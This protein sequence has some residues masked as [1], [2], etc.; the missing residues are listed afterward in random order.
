MASVKSIL[1]TKGTNVVILD[2]TT[3]VLKAVELMAEVNIGCVIVGNDEEALGVFTER[4]LLRRVVSA[5]RAP[6]E[7]VLREVMSCPLKICNLGDDVRKCAEMFYK[8]HVRH[9]AVVGE[10]V[11]IGLISLRDVLG[12][13]RRN[14]REKLKVIQNDTSQGSQDLLE[15]SSKQG[16]EYGF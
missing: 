12:S 7:V 6:A 3:T 11:L 5:G 1:I 14:S 8:L 16:Y 2:P 10:G 13:E 4:D 15:T 9:L